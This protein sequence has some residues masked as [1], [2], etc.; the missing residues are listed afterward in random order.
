MKKYDKLIRK[1]GER[2]ERKYARLS[3]KEAE[4][5][6]YRQVGEIQGQITNAKT[7]QGIPFTYMSIAINGAFSD[8][9]GY[10]SIKHIPSGRYN[11]KI[12]YGKHQE[13]II[14]DVQVHARGITPLNISI[15]D[16]AVLLELDFNYELTK[17][18]VKKQEEWKERRKKIELK[19]KEAK[20]KGKNR[21]EKIIIRKEKRLEVKRRRD[22]E[23]IVNEQ[24]QWEKQNE[25]RAK[26]KTTK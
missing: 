22:Y 25:K 24:V 2:W 17:K 14:L 19:A 6:A 13:P 26:A 1:K 4:F 9:D 10:Y 21:Y 23:K 20:R 3:E 18:A 15:Y 12:S 16:E 7:G 5:F 8:F 11:V